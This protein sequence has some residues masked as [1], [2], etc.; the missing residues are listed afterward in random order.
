MRSTLH[1]V[2]ARDYLAWAPVLAEPRARH[3]ASSPFRRRLDGLDLE[4]VTAAG[5][6]LIA[7]EPLGGAELGR[8][9]QTRWPD[10]DAEALGHAVLYRA[11]PIQVTPRGVWG[12]AARAHVLG[13]P[14]ARDKKFQPQASRSLGQAARRFAAAY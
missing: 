7:V 1:L 2:T 13:C 3:F 4:E 5:R 8:R 11:L 14:I 6:E 12:K 9:L 10:R